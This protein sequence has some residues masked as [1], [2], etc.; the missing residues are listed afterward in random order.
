MDEKIILKI[1][2][3]ICFIGLTI[4]YFY[5]DDF[6]LSSVETIDGFAQDSLV[7]L[8]GKVTKLSVQDKV[9]FLTLE[10]FKVENTPIILF[11]NQEIYLKE[12]DYVEIEGTIEEYNNQK[13]VIANKVMLK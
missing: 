6:N 10:G 5:A 12:G 9:T 3:I 4:L 13:E 11:N 7:R 2:I 8:E 1:S